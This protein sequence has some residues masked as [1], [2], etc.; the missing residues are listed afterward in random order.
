MKIGNRDFE[1]AELRAE[2]ER[3]HGVRSVRN[4]IGQTGE[5]ECVDCGKPID[6]ARREAA[7]FARRCIGCQTIHERAT[8]GH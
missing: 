1:L 6:K 8:R 2:Q 3:D 5:T 7:P 4:A